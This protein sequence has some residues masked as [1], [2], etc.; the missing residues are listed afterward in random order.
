MKQLIVSIK[1]P[2]QALNDFRDA[3]SRSRRGQQTPTYEV[4]F[5]EKK[6]FLR[7]TEN[8]HILSAI[9]IH[10]PKSIYELAQ[11]LKQDVSNLNKIIQFFKSV[12]VIEL[13]EERISGRKVQR[14]IVHYE[15]IQFRL[16]A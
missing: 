7:F 11:K 5:S 13:K 15:A 10:K 12:G 14:P 6:D 2:T 3:L 9:R 8:M 1:T 4:A 16:A